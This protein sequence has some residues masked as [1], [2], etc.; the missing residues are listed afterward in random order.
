MALGGNSR[1]KNNNAVK[2]IKKLT[3]VYNWN[4]LPAASIAT[5]TGWFA[6]A[7]CKANSSYSG[8]CS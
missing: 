2:L 5:L 7:F 4:S 3:D 1:Y 8:T 6:T